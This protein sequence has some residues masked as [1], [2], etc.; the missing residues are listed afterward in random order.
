MDGG[1]E[2]RWSAPT[3]ALHWLSAALIL[4]LLGLGWFMVHADLGAATKFDLYQLHKS[5]GFL[6]LA[7][8]LLRLGARLVQSSPPAPPTMPHWERRLAGLTHATFYVLLLVAVLSGWLLAS[9]A[10]IAIPTRFFDL[11]VIPNLVDADATLSAEMT[12]LHYMVSRLL[13]G[14]LVLHIAAALKHH[15]L[16]RDDVLR[17]MVRFR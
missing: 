17:R 1:S 8:L 9:A 15:F 16:D 2:Q 7:L 3:I 14:L 4:V 12:F 13:M 10:I 5:L 6:S 11:F